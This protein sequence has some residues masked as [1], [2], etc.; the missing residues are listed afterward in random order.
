MGLDDPTVKM[1][2]S[3]AEE[4]GGHAI[5][6]LDPPKKIR[7]AIMR[8]VTDSLPAVDSGHLSPG[9]E[10]LLTI[11]EVLSGDNREAALARFDGKG[12]GV[13]KGDVADLALERVGAIQTR[14]QEIQAD[15]GYVDRVLADGA[16]RAAAVANETLDKVLHLVGLR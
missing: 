5:V 2:K 4:R 6:L 7:S 10:N 8:A 11:W 13:L 16:E 12:Y 3:L 9:V 1:S 15:K 14:Y